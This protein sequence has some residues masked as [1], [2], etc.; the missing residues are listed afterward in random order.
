MRS[1]LPIGTLGAIMLAAPARAE[2]QLPALLSDHMVVPRESSAPLWG[3]A[4]PGASVVA[5][6][7]WGATAET[8]ADADGRFRLAL[9]TPA[10]PGPWTIAISEGET[11]RRIDDVLAG[12]LWLCSGQSN[13]QMPLAPEGGFLGVE[14]WEAEVAAAERADLRLFTVPR[15]IALEPSDDVEGRWVRCTPQ[16]ARSFS[17]VGYFFGARLASELG[18]P[19]GLIDSTWGGTASEAWTSRG[20]LADFPE[21]APRLAV[22]D[23]ERADPRGAEFRFRVALARWWRVLRERDPGTAGRWAA[24]E[25]DLSDW[26][27][28]DVPGLWENTLGEFDGVVWLRRR[29]EVPATWEGRAVTLALGPVDD[30]DSVFLDGKQVGGVHEMGHWAEPR[31]YALGPLAPG[32]HVLAIRILDTGGAGGTTGAPEDFRLECDGAEPASLPLAGTWSAHR[33]VALGELPPFPARSA[34]NAHTPTVLFNGMIAPL[35]PLRLNG[36]VWYQGESNRYDPELYRR[37]FPALIRDWRAR[38]RSPELPF[39]F[40]QIAPFAYG[41]DSGE[42]AA[43]REAQA[44]ALAL[45]ATGMV[46]TMDI[47][48]RRDIHPRKKRPVGERL[49]ALALAK[50]YGRDVPCEGPTLRELVATKGGL[51]VRFDHAEGLTTSDGAPPCCFEVAGEDGVFH[52]ARAVIEGE[53]VLVTSDAVPSPRALRYAWGA[54]DMTNLINGAGLPAVPFRATLPGE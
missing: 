24:P 22:L 26:T 37:L 32:V 50:V 21:L 51:L 39:L 47:G 45:P 31:R 18:T 34:I 41:G 49:A 11:V 9:D 8:T 54:A 43:V 27:T 7:S 35:T 33:G 3:R 42:T 25:T 52:P 53:G 13:M 17:A 15:R 30:M 28:L 36:V 38:F 16:T 46:V 12:E 23:A 29:V 4:T 44:G 40:V 5:R 2:L 1:L 10:E 6:G 48:E 14:D 20:G 19:V